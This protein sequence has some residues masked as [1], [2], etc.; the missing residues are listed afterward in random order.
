MTTL[1]TPQLKRLAARWEELYPS[2]V[3]SGIV[4][5]AAHGRSGYHISRQDA[6]A[7]DYSVTRPDDRAGNGP[8]NVAAAVDMSMNERDM[9]LCTQRLRSLFAAVGDPR[10]KYVNAFNGWL[11]G[12][13]DA[14]RWDFV[15]G[16]I[17]WATDDHKW[18]VHL[19]LRRKYATSNTAVDEILSVLA[20]KSL[21]GH[22]GGDDELSWEDDVIPIGYPEV[23]K[24]SNNNKWQAANA[25]GDVRD[26]AHRTL[27][28][29]NV[30]IKGQNSL[31]SSV[32]QLQKIV[33][34]LSAKVD[35]MKASK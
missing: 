26:R 11:G 8:N 32:A 6:N 20:G 17:T 4:G 15:A 19:E 24:H 30:L 28:L 23:W 16:T 34:E 13:A 10:R 35:A 31:N 27:D 21:A 5:D 22:T 14:Q 3:T 25:L 29:V 18:H 1:A 7:G 2:A 33:A 12:T 9:R